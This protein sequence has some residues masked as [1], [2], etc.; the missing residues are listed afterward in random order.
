M[1]PFLT[2]SGGQ[3]SIDG[4][5]PSGGWTTNLLYV[6]LFCLAVDFVS[7]LTWFWMRFISGEMRPRRGPKDRIV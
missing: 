1:I 4:W 3:L 7:A 6:V 2:E 5:L